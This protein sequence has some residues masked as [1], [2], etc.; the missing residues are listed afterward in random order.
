MPTMRATM[1]RTNGT[2]IAGLCIGRPST[3]VVV[4]QRIITPD[5]LTDSR[6]VGRTKS[7]RLTRLCPNTTVLLFGQF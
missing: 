5:C 7:S 1:M 4:H 2:T 3:Y 6:R